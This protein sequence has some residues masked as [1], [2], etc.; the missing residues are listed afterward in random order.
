MELLLLVLAGL[1]LWLFISGRAAGNSGE[2]EY[3]RPH[4]RKV[5]GH[6]RTKSKKSRKKSK[7]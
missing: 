6:Y 1:F 2:K 4:T 5:K 3:V 7:W